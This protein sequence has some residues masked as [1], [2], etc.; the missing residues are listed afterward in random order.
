[1]NKFITTSLAAGL[2]LN[3]Y[4]LGQDGPT[5]AD[6]YPI[7]KLPVPEGVVL[8]VSGIEA[9][10]DK[11]IAVASR[12]GD[13]YTIEG[14]Y[15][16]S[17]AKAKWNLY[18]QGLHESLG[19]AWVKGWLYATQRPEVS[20][21]RDSDGD[22]AADIFESVSS[23][24]GICG[25]YHEYAFGSRPDKDGNIW[26]VLCLTGSGGT[27]ADYRGWCVRITPGGEMIPAASGIRSPGGI[28]QNHLGDMFYSDNQGP[29]NGSSSMKHLKP[30]S[31]QGNPTGNVHYALTDAIGPRPE[32][33]QSGSRIATEAGRIPEF[34]PPAIIFPHGEMG[35]S[36]SGIECDTSGGK[37][38]PFENQLLVCDQTHST[39]QRVFLE[40]VNG[41]YQGAC[42]PFIGGFGSGNVAIR[43]TP[44]GALF[45][46]G[47]NRG[48][49]SR[50]RQN[51][52]FER[53][54]WTGK[55]PFEVHEMRSKP[56]GFELTFTK[57]ADRDS[58]AALES[59][60][61]DAFTYIYQSNYGSPVVDRETLSVT[62]ATP[63]DDGKS[64][65]LVLNKL[66]KGHVHKL[67]LPGLRSADGGIPLLHPVAY[68]TL[69]QIPEP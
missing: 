44:D 6:Y 16:K 1:M 62:K 26:V 37:F 32:D 43:M 21:L 50:G 59:Y 56:N 30:G 3:Y 48:W 53:V 49:G 19:I 5:E 4:A 60:E 64:V 66:I 11:K 67:K 52:A 15:S 40:K 14:A 65:R 20:R 24:W 51:F 9:L 69:N 41:V 8:E 22:G 54:D 27:R 47:T 31:F 45:V 17:P 57:P 46:G 68:Y 58:L 28:G 29:W 12:R 39:V 36:T 23:G 34:V 10:P 7:T 25:D 55:V 35:Q 13:I 63:G 2:F 33:P 38:G 42:F 18:A 61:I